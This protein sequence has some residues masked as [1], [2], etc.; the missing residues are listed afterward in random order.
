M[1]TR[2]TT[3]PQSPALRTPRY[4][5]GDGPRPRDRGQGRA[6]TA[7]APRPAAHTSH[8]PAHRPEAGADARHLVRSVLDAR[9]IGDDAAGSVVLVVSELV[10]NAVEHTQPPLVLRHAAGTTHRARQPRRNLTGIP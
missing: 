4:A 6:R 9:Q 8:G 2:G 3:H 1:R 10:T 5:A 7:G